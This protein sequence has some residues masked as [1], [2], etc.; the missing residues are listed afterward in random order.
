MSSW[1]DV[2]ILVVLI[3]LNGMFALSEVALITSRR[4]RLQHMSEEEMPGAKRAMEMNADPNRALST[5]QVG[6]RRLAYSRV[7]LGKRRSQS[8][9]P[10]G[11]CPWG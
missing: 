9:W 4:A 2:L 6:L 8:P 1:F 11:W 5:I 7:F 3:G 10:S